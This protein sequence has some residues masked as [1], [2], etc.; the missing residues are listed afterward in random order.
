MDTYTHVC[1]RC[2]HPCYVMGAIEY[3]KSNCLNNGCVCAQWD[4]VDI[5]EIKDIISR[6]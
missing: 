5:S 6:R 3:P 4:R 2:Y 1:R